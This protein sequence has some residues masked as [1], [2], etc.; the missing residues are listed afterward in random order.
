MQGTPTVVWGLAA[1]IAAAYV[2]FAFAGPETQARLLDV[3]ALLP[4]RYEAG[5]P[6]G[7]SGPVA[8]AL[9]L[10]GH[11]FLHGGFLHLAMNMIVFLQVAGLVAHR[12]ELREPGGLK[13]LGLF[14]ASAA[15]GGW[16]YLALNPGSAVPGVGASGAVCGLFAA[17]LLAVR[18]DWRAALREPRVQSAAFWF[19]AVNVGL[20]AIARQTG[21]LPIAWEAHLGGFVG[22]ALVYA[23]L[24]GRVREG[25][26]G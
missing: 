5:G 6:Y 23:L 14:F 20:A 3:A 15:A 12:L 13:F 9:P 4:I 7:Y 10:F 26:W 17:Y 18:R 24:I 8:A 22:G 2:G 21:L 11:V 19:L 1:A 25:P 16:L